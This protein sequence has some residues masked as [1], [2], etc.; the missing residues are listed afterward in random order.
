MAEI[1]Y[2]WYQ[3][4]SGPELQQGDIL[5]DCPHFLIPPIGQIGGVIDV[6]VERGDS[7]V[8]SQSCDLEAG[9][10]EDVV[11]CPVYSREELRH[12]PSL[13]KTHR[14]EDI[15]KGRMPRFQILNRC[16]LEGHSRDYSLVDLAKIFTL[17]I[18]LVRRFAE[19]SGSRIRLLPPYREQLSQSFARFY[20]RVGLPVDL[21]KFN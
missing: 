15:R 11:L 21:P 18:D 20:M 19:D 8:I 7:I 16:E 9:K 3:V 4:T 14:W 6:R 1:S 10:I 12:D 13:G 2:P 5:S 17:P